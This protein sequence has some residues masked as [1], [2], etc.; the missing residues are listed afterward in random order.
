MCHVETCTMAKKQPPYY[1]M[2]TSVGAQA[3]YLFPFAT[4]R[5]R[6]NTCISDNIT[7]AK[8]FP[9]AY[10]LRHMGKDTSSLL[11]AHIHAQEQCLHAHGSAFFDR[12]VRAQKPLLLP[13]AGV[14]MGRCTWHLPSVAVHK[15]RIKAPYPK[16]R[17]RPFVPRRSMLRFTI[18]TSFMKCLPMN[19]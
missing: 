12:V 3:T 19:Q 9:V 17:C 4:V 13:L 7:R 10:V 11:G 15:G 8:A 14:H 16:I 1:R 18:R 6:S 5:R 2:S